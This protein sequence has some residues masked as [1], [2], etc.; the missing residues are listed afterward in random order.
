[1]RTHTT[2]A[3]ATLTVAALALAGCSS[4]AAE[5]E[6][7]PTATA[8]SV[9]TTSEAE[10]VDRT[11]EVTAGAA[12]G[13]QVT[14]ATETEPGRMEVATTLVDPRGEDGSAE[15]QTAL[16]VCRAAVAVLEADGAEDRYVSVLEE[17][18]TTWVLYSTGQLPGGLP[19]G[20]CVEY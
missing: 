5:D 17:D 7:P 3:A 15:A 19:S 13:D 14:S 9:T 2:I 8:P 6:T 18:G 10:P 12:W 16:E 20:E 1:M 4:D 11:A